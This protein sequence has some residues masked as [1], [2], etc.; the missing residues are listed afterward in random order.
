MS[1]VL[2]WLACLG[3]FMALLY[4]IPI[5][6]RAYYSPDRLASVD[7]LVENFER[8]VF[9]VEFGEERNLTHIDK[10]Q[11]PLRYVLH[12]EVALQFLPVL[13][14]HMTSLGR[15]TGL[16]FVI[17]DEMDSIG[18]VNLHFVPH[19]EMYETALRY[20]KGDEGLQELVRTG[21]CIG[22]TTSREN[23]NVKDFTIISTDYSDESIESCLLEE[24][25]QGLGMPNDSELIRPSIFSHH[26]E[27]VELTIND[28]ILVRTLY[29]HRIKAGMPKVR[30]MALAREIILEL[31]TLVK[32]EGE[33][34]LYQ[35]PGWRVQ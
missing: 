22:I 33:E 1:V 19:A 34:A 23:I 2:R 10:W 18:N 21:S 28:M 30:A 13:K 5:G 15:L 27:P 16:D 12:E 32:A 4:A 24:M 35:S 9:H 11:S 7:R 17:E 3:F 6:Y 14:E 29:D 20:H 25:V 31:V 26:D 8:V